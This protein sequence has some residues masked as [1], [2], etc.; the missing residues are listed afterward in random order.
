MNDFPAFYSRN[1]SYHVCQIKSQ[2]S[3]S[4]SLSYFYVNNWLIYI[5][6]DTFC[7]LCKLSGIN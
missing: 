4:N 7:T 1:L 6:S 2:S 3:M 5:N